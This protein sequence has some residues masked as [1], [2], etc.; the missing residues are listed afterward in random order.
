[1][2]TIIQHILVMFSTSSSCSQIPPHLPILTKEKKKRIRGPWRE[3]D[4]ERGW[5]EAENQGEAERGRD[6]GRADFRP[7]GIK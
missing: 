1:M 6:G 2:E 5:R 4:K 7:R 3:Q